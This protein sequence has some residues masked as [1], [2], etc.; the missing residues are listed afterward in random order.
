MEHGYMLGTEVILLHGMGMAVVTLKAWMLGT[1]GPLLVER[2][3]PF[4]TFFCPFQ[5]FFTG[6]LSV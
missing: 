6:M 2:A 4:F 3:W 1:A 5:I